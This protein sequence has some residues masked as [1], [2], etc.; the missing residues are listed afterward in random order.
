M[1]SIQKLIF[2]VFRACW[3]EREWDGKY[4]LVTPSNVQE[5]HFRKITQLTQIDPIILSLYNPT[6][7]TWDHTILVYYPTIQ[8][9]IPLFY[10]CNV[11][12]M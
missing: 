5:S 7:E 2:H 6:A 1:L 12:V 11:L 4:G 9:K 10:Y 8:G 3:S